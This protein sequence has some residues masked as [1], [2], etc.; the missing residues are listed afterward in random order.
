M[1]T[2]IDLR[3]DTV[4][5]PTSAMRAAM[6]AAPVGD[7]VFGD[8]PSVNAL[9]ARMAAL[10]GKE[11]ALLLPTGT[12]SNLVA[13][14]SH[15]QRGDEYIVGQHYHTYFY[16]AGGAAVLGSIQ[17]QPLPVQADGTLALEDIEA[18]IKAD[19]V[20]FA[21]SR[22]LAMENTHGGRVMPDGYQAQVRAL[23]DRHG[24]R[25]HL[26]G[27]RLFNAAVASGRSL[28]QLAANADSVSLCCSK[29]LG[30]PLGSVLVGSSAFIRDARRW[31]KMVGGGMRQAGIFAAA[32]DHAL[33]HHVERLAE[34]HANALRLY[35]GVRGLPGVAGCVV[36]TN[37]VYVDL[38]SA[39]QGLELQAQLKAAGILIAG[40]RKIR[41]VTHLDVSAAAI[42]R[43][44]GATA[45]ALG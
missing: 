5:R 10:A 31:R 26:D 4:T 44:I 23:A 25:V 34:D 15:C 18:A 35:E 14:L 20:H 43:V 29:G 39:E 24:L 9:E 7:D 40:G 16:E 2:S 32:I 17:P 12:Q 37:M 27:A 30:A 6:A 45:R 13:L 41:L 33:D 22:L 38:G 21:R 42:D 11:A 36:N 19:D 3:S 1:D 8:D 28:V